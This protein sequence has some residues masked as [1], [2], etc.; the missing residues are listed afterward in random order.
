MRLGGRG[1]L[2]ASSGNLS[3]FECDRE[4]EGEV[5]VTPASRGF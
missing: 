4:G 2:L 3:A 1:E 5:A